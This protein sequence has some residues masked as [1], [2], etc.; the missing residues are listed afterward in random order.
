[1]EDVTIFGNLGSTL[2][3]AAKEQIKQDLTR[4]CIGEVQTVLKLIDI[5]KARVDLSQRQLECYNKRLAAIEAGQVSIVQ[6]QNGSL[7]IR[8]NDEPLNTVP[9][10]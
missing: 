5:T 8:Y 7:I 2:I 1:M 9:K 4:Q 6:G 3:N 10:E